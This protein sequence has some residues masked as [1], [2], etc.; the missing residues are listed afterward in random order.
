VPDATGT[1]AT[2]TLAATAILDQRRCG[3]VDFSQSRRTK[4]RGARVTIFDELNQL[5]QNFLIIPR[6]T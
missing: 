5:L 3:F 4:R 2:G 6:T 1:L